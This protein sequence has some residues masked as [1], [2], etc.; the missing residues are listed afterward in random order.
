MSEIRRLGWADVDTDATLV[1]E[2]SLSGGGK[3]VVGGFG[4]VDNGFNGRMTVPLTESQHEEDPGLF[5]EL[6]YQQA[7]DLNAKLAA[8][9]IDV[10]RER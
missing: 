10:A 5:A 8:V 4:P 6:T 2:K 1:V 3:V 9:L 7:L